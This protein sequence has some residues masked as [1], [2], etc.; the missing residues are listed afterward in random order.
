MSGDK[1]A[2]LGPRALSAIVMLAVG[3]G[4]IWVGGWA[5]LILT[6]VVA[7]AMIYELTTMLAPKLDRLRVVLLA[8]IAAAAVIRVGFD[9]SPMALA[10]LL[11]APALGLVLLPSDRGIYAIY[12]F[13]L[14][15]S[16]AA[17]FWIR[18][19]LGL[20]WTL[21][22]VLTVIASDIG[23]YL[24]GR[25]I[26]GAKLAPSISPGKTWSGTVGGW[27]LVALVASYGVVFGGVGIGIV[28]LGIVVAMASQIG[29]LSES[30]VKR[31]VGVKDASNLIPG[32]GGVMDRFD[33]LSFAA[34][35][36]FLM[37]YFSRL[38]AL[39]WG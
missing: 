37:A 18:A 17:L 22:L 21:W 34:I 13:F 10:S 33:A 2:D 7:G 11:I 9:S 4:A 31:R 32:H 5:F 23:G 12:A 27:V 14:G 36:L 15:F 3:G 38:P 30:W 24:F 39:G 35:A 28:V 16:C 6:A 26:G 25:L 8:I 1:F 20:D 29:D 19:L